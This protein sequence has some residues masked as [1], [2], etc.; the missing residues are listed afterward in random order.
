MEMFDLVSVVIIK[1]NC[2]KNQ[3][4]KELLVAFEFFFCTSYELSLIWDKPIRYF[5]NFNA[6]N[7]FYFEYTNTSTIKKKLGS[8]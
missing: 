8:I 7:F 5:I 6:F 4:Y 1:N 2:V 3:Y